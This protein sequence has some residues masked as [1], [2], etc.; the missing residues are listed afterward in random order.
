[1]LRRLFRR[2]HELEGFDNLLAIRMLVNLARGPVGEFMLVMCRNR[3]AEHQRVDDPDCARL[4][5]P[6]APFRQGDGYRVAAQT[7]LLAQRR[8]QKQRF[9][10]GDGPLP[11][12]E[13][14]AARYRVEKWWLG[15]QTKSRAARG[16]VV[17]IEGK[18]A[19]P[20]VLHADRGPTGLFPLIVE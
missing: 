7:H 14:S 4:H 19:L 1:M 15:F 2:A 11:Q 18:N 17:L 8:P 20:I 13:P 5:G 10:T 3:I 6:I 9:Y 12:R 16:A